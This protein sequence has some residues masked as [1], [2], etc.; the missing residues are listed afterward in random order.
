[1]GKFHV[2]KDKGGSF[3]WR[4][5]SPNGKIIADSAE[6]Y[7]TRQACLEGIDAVKRCA[8]EAEVVSDAPGA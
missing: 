1:M 6:G 8:P 3:R 5:V 4:L 7:T 2:F